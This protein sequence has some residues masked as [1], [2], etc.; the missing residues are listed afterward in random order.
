MRAEPSKTKSCSPTS[1]ISCNR[2]SRP[3]YRS[4][5]KCGGFRPMKSDE[6]V[7][8]ACFRVSWQL[9]L[10]R[11]SILGLFW[12]CWDRVVHF[13]PSLSRQKNPHARGKLD[14]I[15]CWVRK[16]W[17]EPPKISM[18]MQPIAHTSTCRSKR[19]LKFMKIDCSSSRCS[20]IEEHLHL[21]CTERQTKWLLVIRGDHARR[22][23]S[24]NSLEPFR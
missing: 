8:F 7:S 18:K 19:L 16:D 11:G 10:Q 12:L 17:V 22:G 13:A 6:W 20:W 21:L 9:V 15:S 14:P 24:S 2:A 1:R 5:H 23:G 3:F 4:T